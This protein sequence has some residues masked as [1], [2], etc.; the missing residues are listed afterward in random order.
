MELLH[1][2][3]G[4]GEIYSCFKAFTKLKLSV[5]CILYAEIELGAQSSNKPETPTKDS[6]K[7]SFG[8]AD[9]LPR[10]NDD[11]KKA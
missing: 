9:H 11:V 7:N 10:G 2:R 3:G 5:K 6:R 1:R 4:Y 8:D